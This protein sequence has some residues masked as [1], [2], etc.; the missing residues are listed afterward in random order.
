ME[1]GDSDVLATSSE[2]WGWCFSGNLLCL[3]C[4]QL[5][6]TRAV[7]TEKGRVNYNVEPLT[8]RSL[9]GI[10]TPHRCVFLCVCV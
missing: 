5:F 8:P 2:S 1:D 3:C 7:K 6:L 10:N 4:I 9:T